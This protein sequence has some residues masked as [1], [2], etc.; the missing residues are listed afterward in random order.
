LPGDAVALVLRD[1]WTAADDPLRGDIASAWASPPLWGAGGR[2]ALLGVVASAHGPGALEAAAAVLHRRDAD[3]EIAALAAA[4]VAQ[5]IASGS[6]PARMQAI[7]QAPL[8]RPDLLTA[9]KAAAQAEDLEVRLAALARLAARGDA[10]A[11]TD[12]VTLAQPGSRVRAG[13]RLALAEVG[14]RRVQA[15]LE[16]NLGAPAAE[17]R[18]EAAVALAALGVPSRAAPL[19]ADADASVRTQVACTILVASRPRR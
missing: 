3:A 16:Q 15:W 17:D 4:H 11:R 5:S 1:L 10:Q 14:D 6:R 9:L 19:L 2:E 13:A 12:L 18:L 8:E 7:A